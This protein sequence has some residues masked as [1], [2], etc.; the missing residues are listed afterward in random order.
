MN[1]QLKPLETFLMNDQ[2][3]TC[4]LCGSRCEI[5]PSVISNTGGKRAERRLR[6]KLKAAGPW[7]RNL[8]NPTTSPASK[9]SPPHQQP[10]IQ[11][12][13]FNNV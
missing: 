6:A 13:C 3:F 10:Q 4:P 1:K 9:Q 2:P 7:M 5:L 12:N 8:L 11:T